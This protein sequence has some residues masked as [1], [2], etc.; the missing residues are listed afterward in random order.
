MK[1]IASIPKMEPVHELL[2]TD[3][4]LMGICGFNGYQVRNGSCER[5]VKLRKM[6]PPEI[7][8]AICVGTLANQM[9]KIAPRAMENFFNGCIQCLAQQGF[10]PKYIHCACDA[11]DYETTDKYQ[12]CGSTI[13]ERKVRAEV[14]ETAESSRPSRS[15]FTVGSFGPSM[16][17]TPA[18]PWRLRSIRS[19]NRT[20]SISFPS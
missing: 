18:F 20:I 7:R 6:P 17:S 2:L 8:G 13:R 16:K 4:L 5:G 3:E 1:T 15:A 11:T 19:K 10:F 14:A 9:V 12:G